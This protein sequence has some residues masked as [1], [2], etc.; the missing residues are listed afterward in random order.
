MSVASTLAGGLAIN[1]I[2]FG[3]GYIAAPERTGSGWIGKPA[4]KGGTTV[5]T[6][7]LGARDLVLG[8]GALWAMRQGRDS[9]RPWFAAHAVADATDLAATVAAKDSLPRSGFRFALAMAGVSTA[10][11]ILGATSA[12]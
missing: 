1:R 5:L 7:A 10:I 11:A 6:R 12:D 4:E 8:A 9:A 3:L 2:A